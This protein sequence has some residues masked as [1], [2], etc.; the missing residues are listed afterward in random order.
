MFCGW[1]DDQILLFNAEINQSYWED[2]TIEFID[3]EGNEQ[4]T[5]FYDKG[6]MMKQTMIIS[7]VQA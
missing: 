3:N 7:T 6:Y 2:G 5:A 4:Q 1:T